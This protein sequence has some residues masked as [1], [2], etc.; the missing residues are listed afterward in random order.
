VRLFIASLLASVLSGYSGLVGL[1]FPPDRLLFAAGAFLLLLDGHLHASGRLRWRWV[2]GFM[3]AT[4]A[5]AAW[6]ASVHGTLQT[7]Y[8]AF[9]LLDRLVIPFAFLVLGPVLFA[10]ERDRIRLL[11]ALIALGAYLGLTAI[12]EIAGLDSLV[13]PRYTTDPDVGIHFGRARGPFAGA[14]ANGMAMAACLF[15][16]ALA[17]SRLRGMW[18][19]AAVCVIALSSVG[20]L[21][22]LTR[23]VWLGTIAGILIV[24]VMT[25]SLRRWLPL[26]IG[27]GVAAM[28]GL[29]VAVPALTDVLVERLTTERSVYD[30]QNTNAAA[31]RMI[32]EH[33]IDGVGWVRFVDLSPDWVRQADLYPVTNV[34]IEVHNVVLARAAELGLVGAFLWCAAV[35]AGPAMAVLRT[36]ADREL[37]PWR[38]IFVGYGCVWLTCIML[39]PV[40]YPLPNYLIWL[41]AGISLRD[42]L[43]RRPSQDQCQQETS[44][45]RSGGATRA[46][47][48]T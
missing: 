20:I 43:V 38:M 6:S 10:E 47:T 42:Y 13:F 4:V 24:S 46:R 48:A 26:I 45:G 11:K 35:L 12:F 5:W 9:A 36:S 17:V 7:S 31:L 19:V 29:L 44:S 32:A 39:S 40:P 28:A 1:P 30:R 41:L 3:I 21:L 25:P 22:T 37:A 33:P 16:S 23:S 14:E 27:G 18:R 34:A 2:H 15:A 8:G